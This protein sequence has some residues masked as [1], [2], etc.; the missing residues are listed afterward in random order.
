MT[1]FF[2]FLISFLSFFL[3]PTSL[4]LTV[5]RCR[6][7]LLHVSTHKDTYTRYDSP[8]RAI[9]ESQEDPCTPAGFEPAIPAN[10]RPL[11]LAFMLY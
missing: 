3:S 5:N 2:A 10:E 4:Y 11:I 8:E 6:E 7:L 1:G 9:G